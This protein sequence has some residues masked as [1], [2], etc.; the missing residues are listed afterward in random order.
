[1]LSSIVEL[2]DLGVATT[3][4]ERWPELRAQA[5]ARETFDSDAYSRA[6][7]V[8]AGALDLPLRLDAEST[9]LDQTRA[10]TGTSRRRLRWVAVGV[11]LLLAAGVG[12]WYRF[13]IYDTFADESPMGFAAAPGDCFGEVNSPNEFI[14]AQALDCNL[15]HVF[16]YLGSVNFGGG[17]NAEQNCAT[18][19]EQS[20][21]GATPVLALINECFAELPDSRSGRVAEF[22][23]IDDVSVGSCVATTPDFY[24]TSV[25][26]AE[27][28]GA[29][30]PFLLFSIR[31]A[32]TRD[33]ATSVMEACYGGV[34]GVSNS[35]LVFTEE[36]K[37]GEAVWPT[38]VY[39]FSR[40]ATADR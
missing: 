26:T 2:H 28:D 34:G 17:D 25:V 16:E 11:V 9:V 15:N 22:S 27:C 30:V 12:A 18:A 13:E 35:H 1:M 31:T 20:T 4:P 24:G 39:C 29:G 19:V 21:P 32:V 23:R 33:A 8:W 7:H 6:L 3:P 10:D 5:A 14:S 37:G 38:D 36:E 40:E